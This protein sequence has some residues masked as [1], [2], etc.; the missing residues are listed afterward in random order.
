M[1]A[2]G[3]ENV[4][5]RP[6]RKR[7]ERRHLCFDNEIDF[8][9][10]HEMQAHRRNVSSGQDVIVLPSR[11]PKLKL[12]KHSIMVDSNLHSRYTKHAVLSIT[13]ERSCSLITN[14]LQSQAHEFKVT[15]AP[16]VDF[17]LLFR[18]NCLQVAAY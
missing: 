1:N 4:T 10:L 7:S 16:E 6:S 15:R 5:S 18:G 17:F 12:S 13:E 2:P 3:E 9:A 14:P 8:G 11:G